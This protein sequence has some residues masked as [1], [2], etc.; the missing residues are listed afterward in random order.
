MGYNTTGK[1]ISQVIAKA[2]VTAHLLLRKQYVSMARISIL[3]TSLGWNASV[4]FVCDRFC[5]VMY[6]HQLRENEMCRRSE[7]VTSSGAALLD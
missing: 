3:I 6:G 7:G 5:A 2:I 1:V 4:L